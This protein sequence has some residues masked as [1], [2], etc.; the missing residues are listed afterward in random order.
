MSTSVRVLSQVVR[1]QVPCQERPCF[2]QLELWQQHVMLAPACGVLLLPASLA[3]VATELQA[4]AAESRAECKVRFLSHLLRPCY[5][6]LRCQSPLTLCTQM[7]CLET[8]ERDP[9]SLLP[10]LVLCATEATKWKF[11]VLHFNITEGVIQSSPSWDCAAAATDD[12][13]SQQRSGFSRMEQEAAGDEGSVADDGLDTFVA[14]CG[15]WLE[16]MAHMGTW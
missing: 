15:F 3:E 10:S 5:S 11:L 7:H 1:I 9:L 8:E 2:V 6:S 13:G 4:R 16:E 14:D 12:C